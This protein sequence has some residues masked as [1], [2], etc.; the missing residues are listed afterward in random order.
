LC[1]CMKTHT[2]EEL[3]KN[4]DKMKLFIYVYPE[5]YKSVKAI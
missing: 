3:Q 2:F 4:P 5:K 1:L